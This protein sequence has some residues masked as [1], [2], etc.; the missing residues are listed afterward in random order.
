MYF[1][2]T[3]ADAPMRAAIFGDGRDEPQGDRN[4]LEWV[5]AVKRRA[6]FVASERDTS[7]GE[8]PA[9]AWRALLPYRHA[10]PFIAA[11][12]EGD[13]APLKSRLLRGLSRSD[14]TTPLP[15]GRFALRVAHS[16]ANRLT[17]LKTFAEEE[18]R[19]SIIGRRGEIVEGIPHALALTHPATDATLRIT[20][21]LFEALC[22]FA[23]GTDADIPAYRPLLEDLAA[24]K[25]VVRR[26]GSTDLLLVEGGRRFHRLTQR[27]RKIVREDVPFDTESDE[28]YEINETEA[29]V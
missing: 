17:V 11:L 1:H 27:G 7:A 26:G 23:E 25:N 19:L 12:E 15:S 16:D 21:D 14:G 5:A 4:P 2:D 9:M 20:L 3:D 24:F 28:T 22:R 18:F 13:A 10:K 6:Y 8:L 29:R